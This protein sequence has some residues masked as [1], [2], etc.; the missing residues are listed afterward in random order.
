MIYTSKPKTFEP[1]FEVVSC[2]VQVEEEIL[3]LKRLATKSQGGKWGLPA[4]KIDPN[5]TSNQAMI[6][7]IFEETG[8]TVIEEDLNYSAKV[9][10]QYSDIDFIYHMFSVNLKS[11]PEIK[12]RDTE[13]QEY[14]WITPLESLSLNLVEDLD[15]CTKMF[16]NIQ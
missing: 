11:K 6:R 13:H 16:Y 10:V 9:Y 12:I 14:K 3:L 15:A 5:E 1:R 8:L 7:E 2:Y 4:G